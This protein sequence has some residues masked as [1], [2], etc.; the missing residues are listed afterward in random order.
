MIV[1]ESNESRVMQS[2]KDTNQTTNSRE[3]KDIEQNL[4]TDKSTDIYNH[5]PSVISNAV[6]AYMQMTPIQPSVAES[7]ERLGAQM[8]DA[9]FVRIFKSEA[10]LEVWMK[11]DKIFHLIQTYPICAHSGELGPKLAEGDGQSPEGFYY[12]KK[13]QLNPNSNY[14]LAFNIGYPNRFDK[15]HNRSGSFIMVH[16][17][18]VSIG[19]YAMTD[20]KIEEIYELVEEA[21]D[22]GQ[23]YVRV[24]IFPFR[25]SD[26]VMSGYIG[27]EWY[28]FWENLKEGYELF[29]SSKI[30]PNV[31]VKEKRYIFD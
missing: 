15:A 28:G 20:N 29:E 7:I 9:V 23:R 18:C 26:D 14:H 24:H 16:G 21:L 4:S 3:T 22:H 30:P 27:H 31:R 17:S 12:V 1:D 2:T 10:V 5:I 8:G 13:R 6:K 25:M 19:C 11:H